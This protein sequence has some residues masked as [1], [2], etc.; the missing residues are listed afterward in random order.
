MIKNVGRKVNTAW[1]VC[2]SKAMRYSYFTG[3]E[4][5]RNDEG[6]SKR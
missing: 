6:G 5:K 3:N 4:A 2:F 1:F